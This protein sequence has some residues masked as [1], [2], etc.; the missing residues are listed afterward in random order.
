M[1]YFSIL[2]LDISWLSLLWCNH[3]KLNFFDKL[4]G[5]TGA[6]IIIMLCIA[7]NGKRLVMKKRRTPATPDA[8]PEQCAHEI[9]KKK[10]RGM[11]KA[12][13][14]GMIFVL[15]GS[16]GELIL[17]VSLC[18]TGVL[19]GHLSVPHPQPCHLRAFRV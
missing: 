12:V 16:A 1:G 10:I 8:P 15:R 14:C 6:F 2:R 11:K 13:C 18:F 7:I 4:V 3:H 5:S 17:S 9:V 19:Y